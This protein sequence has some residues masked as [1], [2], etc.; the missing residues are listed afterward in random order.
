[1]IKATLQRFLH[2][3][4]TFGKLTFDNGAHPDIYTL[5]LPFKDNLPNISCIPQGLYNAVK[6]SSPAHPD[7]WEILNVPDRSAILMHV[8]NYAKDSKG[9]ILLGFG[10]NESTPMITRSN[11]CIE[12]LRKYLDGNNFSLEILN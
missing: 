12:F 1:M 7:V 10:I 3:E 4:V 5:E 2:G 8:G 6:Y 9:C 11:K